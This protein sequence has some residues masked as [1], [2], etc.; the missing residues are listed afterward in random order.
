METLIIG[1]SAYGKKRFKELERETPKLHLYV[2]KELKDLEVNGIVT[3]QFM[4]PFHS[5]GPSMNWPNPG[6]HWKLFRR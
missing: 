1:S 3:A 4:I 6:I 2:S 5:N